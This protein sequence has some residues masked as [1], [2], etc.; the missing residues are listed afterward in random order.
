MTPD[1]LRTNRPIN[2]RPAIER[3]LRDRLGKLKHLALDLD[4]TLYL[5]GTLFPF[6]H[7]F[8][9][10]L[11]RLGVGYTFFTN[12][13]SRSTKQYVRHL[14]EMGINADEQMFYSSTH[15]TVDHLRR[16][17]P[18]VRR[19][20]V[21]GTAGLQEELSELGYKISATRPEVVVVGYD[22]DLRYS[23]MSQAAYWINRGLPFLATHPDLVCPTDKPLVLPDCGAICQLLTAATGRA[24]DAVLGKPNVG[25][26]TGLLYRHGLERDEVAMVGDRLYTDIAMARDAGVLSILVLSG[27]TKLAGLDDNS[28]KPDVVIDHVGKFGAMLSAAREVVGS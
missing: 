28:C 25:M 22:T 6:T 7:S 12:N 24:P 8:L 19:L 15:A 16:A 3:D 27:E 1:T 13:S 23:R 21:L 4:G 18:D 17:Y 26:L 14:G 2:N 10:M 9:D 5:G 20:F 11:K